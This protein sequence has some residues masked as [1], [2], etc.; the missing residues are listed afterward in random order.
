MLAEAHVGISGFAYREWV[1]PVYP[2][3]STAAQLLPLYAERL[4]AVEIVTTYTRL[5]S[6]EQIAAWAQSVPPGFEFCFKAP[7]RITHELGLKGARG[8]GAF[9]D[10]LEPLGDH[11]GPILL[12]VPESVPADR[13]AL[14]TFLAQMPEGLRLAFDFIHP[15]W[16]DEATLRLLSA[17]ECALVLSDFGE[18]APRLEVTADFTY[19]RIQRDDDHPQSIDEWAQRLALPSRRG[20]DVYAFLK[21]DRR[22]AALDR[23]ARLSSLLRSESELADQ[24]MLS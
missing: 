7:N 21:H 6:L 24:P 13:R 16:R 4:S 2:R 5:P 19:V 22:G 10:L 11:L 17:H 9:L 3:G 1:G 15:S 12:Q 20:L 14:A 8:L 18:G 23:A